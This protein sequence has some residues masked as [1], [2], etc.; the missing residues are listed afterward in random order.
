MKTKKKIL[1]KSL[2]CPSFGR[3]FIIDN[4][5]VIIR[6]LDLVVHSFQFK[7]FSCR[8]L[9][10]LCFLFASFSFRSRSFR[11]SRHCFMCLGSTVCTVTSMIAGLACILDCLVVA[12][13][14]EHTLFSL[15]LIFFRS[16][17][18][19]TMPLADVHCT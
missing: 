16:V 12:V 13:S 15:V 10:L 2:A 9:F 6:S 5:G 19:R 11:F 3:N 17:V 18:F 14:T 1:N 8:R 7:F 4:Y